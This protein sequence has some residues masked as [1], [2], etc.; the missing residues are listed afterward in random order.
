MLVAQ[1]CLFPSPGP[2]LS[3]SCVVCMKASVPS[4][5][6]LLF[7]QIGSHAC[8]IISTEAE[9][10]KSLDSC[11]IILRPLSRLTCVL[12]LFPQSGNNCKWLVRF[13]S[14]RCCWLSGCELLCQLY[15]DLDTS[16]HG[17]SLFVLGGDLVPCW[18]CPLLFHSLS[19]D[20]HFLRVST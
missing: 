1:S 18:T 20:S 5:K 14:H 9:L 16:C 2:V 10:S 13:G 6:V 4:S 11:C 7:M 19:Q 8:P 12:C 15:V 17:S 3:I